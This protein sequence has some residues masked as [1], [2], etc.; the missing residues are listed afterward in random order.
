MGQRCATVAAIGA[1]AVGC[2]GGT[3][4][5]AENSW[6]GDEPKASPSS[7][8]DSSAEAP[9]V[10]ATPPS[11]GG[12]T[13][14]V[15]VRHDLSINPK[16]AK[17]ARCT[18]LAVEVGEATDA[19]F[20]WDTGTPSSAAPDT[21][22]IAISPRGV[23]CPGGDADETKRRAS[24][25]AVDRNGSDVTVE[26]EELPEGRPIATG[27]IIKRP[28]AGGSV[29]VRGRNARLPYARETAGHRCKVY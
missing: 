21:L 25:S 24:I 7:R 29:F 18:C 17:T 28:A 2:G 20:T 23:P 6:L 3:H 12:T 26:I 22:A 19:K 1:M 13:G 16:T 27:A 8:P 4:W 11:S 5:S 9:Q 15:G 14:W 10:S